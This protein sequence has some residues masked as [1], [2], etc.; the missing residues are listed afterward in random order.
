[1][2]EILAGLRLQASL[3]RRNPGY[4]LHFLAIPF[5]SAIFLSGVEQA[6]KPSLLAYAVLGPAM[7]GIWVVSLDLGGGIINLERMQQTFELQII[8]PG[9]FSRVLLGRT[10]I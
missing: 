6:G 7:I 4:L 1:M 9:S 3:F 8:A 10:L 2:S 5:F